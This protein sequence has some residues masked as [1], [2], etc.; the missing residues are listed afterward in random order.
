MRHLRQLTTVVHAN[1]VVDL[2]IVILI[3][4]VSDACGCLVAL[5]GS[6]L[7]HKSNLDLEWRRSKL[8]LG[9]V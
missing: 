3:A 1:G 7:C 6:L 4:V 2:A 9:Q 8:A 5:S